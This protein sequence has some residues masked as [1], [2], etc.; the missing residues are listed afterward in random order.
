M[1]GNGTTP[2]VSGTKRRGSSPRSYPKLNLSPT[3]ALK[4]TFRQVH[5]TDSLY[6]DYKRNGDSLWSKLE[7]VKLDTAKL[8]HLFESKSKEMPVTKVQNQ[9]SYWAEDNTATP[10]Y[11]AFCVLGW[12]SSTG[13]LYLCVLKVKGHVCS[14]RDQTGE[15]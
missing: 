15:I 9:L 3:E 10:V 11:L 6:K 13:L 7:P 5:P 12:Y 1:T 8:E 14:D 4:C 2:Q